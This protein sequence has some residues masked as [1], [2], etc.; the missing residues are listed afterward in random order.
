[1]VRRLPAPPAQETKICKHTRRGPRSLPRPAH[2]PRPASH[3]SPPHTLNCQPIPAHAL[4]L[5]LARRCMGTSSRAMPTSHSSRAMPTSH[6]SRA[7]PTSHSSRAMPTSHRSRAM[8]TSHELSGYAHITQISGYAHI[9]R[10]LG[11]CP[12]HTSSRVMPTSHSCPSFFWG[13]TLPLVGF[14]FSHP[15]GGPT[16]CPPL[17]AAHVPVAH[18]LAY[19]I[20]QG[21]SIRLLWISKAPMFHSWYVA[22]PLPLPLFSPSPSSYACPLPPATPTQPSLPASAHLP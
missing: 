11:L 15:S 2:P 14:K 10:A 12:H 3:R 20:P 4:L 6:S 18:A 22:H 1:M 17:R 5:R 16:S 21:W 9:T 8:P 19:G 13:T 7:V